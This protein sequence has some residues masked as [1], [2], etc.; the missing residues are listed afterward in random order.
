MDDTTMTL[1]SGADVDAFARD[2]VVCI[3]GLLDAAWI[4]RMIGAIDR[5]EHNPGPFRERYSSGDPGMFF[6]EKL[7]RYV[8]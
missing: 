5:I 2:G 4:E 7:S 8:L 6:S 1:I 3:R